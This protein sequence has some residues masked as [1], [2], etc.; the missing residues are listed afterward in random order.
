[1]TAGW[2]NIQ[3]INGLTRFDG[4]PVKSVPQVRSYFSSDLIPVLEN[5]R[6]NFD[7]LDGR[8][9]W[10]WI[11]PLLLIVG[12]VVMLFAGV[13]IV[14]TRRG[15]S[16]KEA[17]ATAI[18]VPVVGV[19]V[20]GL[21]LGLALI[22][23]TSNGQKLLDALG[24]AMTKERVAGDRAGI[25]MVSSIVDTEDPIMTASGGGA[26]EVPKLLA[27]VSQKT[28][29]SQAEVLKALQANFPHTAGLLQA[30]PLSSVTAELPKLAEFL[31]PAV[32][33]VPHL[34]QT[35][36]A[37][38]AV[39]SGWD[40]VP[41]T[42]GATRFNGQPIATVP[43]VRTYLGS[44]VVPVLEKQRGNY[45]SLVGTSNIDF[46]GPLVLIIGFVVIAFGLLMVLLALR[47]RPGEAREPT[48]VGP[49]TSAQAA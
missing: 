21:A 6:T 33:S 3:N 43:E 1:M 11:A 14:R 5:Q 23:R 9:A 28:G 26:A 7:S 30:I 24:P 13:M 36:K 35:I 44:D 38:P 19:V 17:V 2:Q 27:F 46:I 39:T 12:L 47:W 31:G 25:N 8:S 49:P 22:P 29:L 18:V 16:H 40:K 34:A 45:Q 37:A 42:Q 20:V 15:V 4:T 48:P 41:G 10:N 32:G